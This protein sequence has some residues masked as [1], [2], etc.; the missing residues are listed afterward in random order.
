[1]PQGPAPSLR[2]S[3][4][5][6]FLVAVLAAVSVAISLWVVT[7]E[8]W[9]DDPYIGM[10]YAAN[11]AAGKGLVF[12]PGERVE[13]YTAWLWVMI[14]Y[15]A[16]LAKVDPMA[17]WQV[18]D[19]G[20]QVVTLFLLFFLAHSPGAR[21]AGRPAWKSLLAPA[22]LAFHVGWVSWAVLGLS[23]PFLA[24]LVTLAVLL[25]ERRGLDRRH[26][27]LALGAILLVLCLTRFDALI[28]AG[29][30]LG[31][32]V[33]VDRDLNKAI[34]AILVLGVGLATYNAWRIS[35]YGELLPNTFHAKQSTLQKDVVGGL[36]YLRL[37]FTTGG[38]YALVLVF[39]PLLA[40]RP[41]RAVKLAAWTSAG[42]LLYVVA[43]GG[44]WMVYHR[45]V[46]PVLPFL[47]LLLQE[48]LW[49]LTDWL[50]EKGWPAR[51]SGLLASAVAAVLLAWNASTIASSRWIGGEAFRRG[52]YWHAA[53]AR[54]VARY[55]DGHLPADALVATEWAGIIPYYMRQPIF[56]IFG[57]NDTA[58]ISGDFPGSKMGRGITPEYLAGR[59]PDVVIVVSRVFPTF[60]EALA[61]LDAR[62]PSLVKDLYAALASPTYG[63]EP[64]V[65]K[66][67]ERGYWPC[68]VRSGSAWRQGL[69]VGG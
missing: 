52:P 50:T 35:Y 10:R 48:G 2:A 56:D 31:W 25:V 14:A 51:R 21:S 4:L 33:L 16:I 27:S 29:L 68:L 7:T 63:Y 64:C 59:S 30:I 58:V 42:H 65:M 55:L 20:G 26:G 9:L 17:V 12:N 28:L 62:P 53:D 15:V 54:E 6:L 13:G 61:G 22:L 8:I 41:S 47:C 49:S 3:R 24:M 45:F 5:A 57:L 11:A 18:L 19:V 60:E 39:L 46:V 66:I 67:G 37:F 23:A 38:P 36:N 69:C 44:D 1:M 43:V 34:P 40:R 32:V